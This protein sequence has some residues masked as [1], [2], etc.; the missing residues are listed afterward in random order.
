M[1]FKEYVYN[2]VALLYHRYW[3]HTVKQLYFDLKVS[4]AE[5]VVLYALDSCALGPLSCPSHGYSNHLV[6][7]VGPGCHVPQLHCTPLGLYCCCLGCF[8]S[9]LNLPDTRAPRERQSAGQPWSRKE[10]VPV[11]TCLPGFC[12]SVDSSDILRVFSSTPQQ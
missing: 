9:S 3:R 5:S 1:I 4:R 6:V 7:R 10:W 11:D 12:A 2:G 8:W